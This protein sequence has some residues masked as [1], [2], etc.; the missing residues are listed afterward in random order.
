MGKT[1]KQQCCYATDNQNH[2]CIDQEKLE[3]YPRVLGPVLFNSFIHDL[4]GTE[5]TL[6]KFAELWDEWLTRQSVVPLSKGYPEPGEN[7]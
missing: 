6:S 1:V 4:D 2:S 7:G 3:M 5:Q